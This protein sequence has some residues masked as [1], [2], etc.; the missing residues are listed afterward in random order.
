MG[1][2][3]EDKHEVEMADKREAAEEAKDDGTICVRL[4]ESKVNLIL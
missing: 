2:D 1:S 4:W 3:A